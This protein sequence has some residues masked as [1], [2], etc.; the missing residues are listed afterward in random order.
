V[1]GAERC[2]VRTAFILQAKLCRFNLG[3]SRALGSRRGVLRNVEANHAARSAMEDSRGT[4]P[5]RNA[6]QIP[7]ASVKRV[8]IQAVLSRSEPTDSTPLSSALANNVRP[9]GGAARHSLSASGNM[10][11]GMFNIGQSGPGQCDPMRHCR[12]LRT[13]HARAW[14]AAFCALQGL[15]SVFTWIT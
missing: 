9:A 13:A 15:L 7:A 12:T 6:R 8:H 4:G 3:F 1:R 2:R 14:A 10:S 11:V 5:Q